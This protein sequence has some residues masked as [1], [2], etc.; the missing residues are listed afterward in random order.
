MPIQRVAPVLA[1]LLSFSLVGVACSSEDASP[2]G[3]GDAAATEDD[4]GGGEGD[5]A[6]AASDGT[7]GK[8]SGPGSD[9]GN[10][11]S[12]ATDSAIKDSAVVDTGP[13]PEVCA[14]G[15][16]SACNSAGAPMRWNATKGMCC[17]DAPGTCKTNVAQA[18]CASVSFIGRYEYW[19]GSACCVQQDQ[20]TCSPNGG[21][22]TYC[23]VS[24][25]HS[26]SPDCCM[27]GK[28]TCTAGTF[29]YCNSQNFGGS[30]AIYSGS[31]CCVAGN[32]T[33]TPKG[34]GACPTGAGTGTSGTSCCTKI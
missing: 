24:G 4:A 32:W 16:Q 19:T 15:T 5:D 2:T 1:L 13:K 9:S 21:T 33:C 12:A 30:K 29:S 11:D 31:E 28:Y 6:S 34:A 23:T 18:D 10:K 17:M 22:K 20:V 7:T 8:D 14:A 26:W 3:G 25:T 27:D